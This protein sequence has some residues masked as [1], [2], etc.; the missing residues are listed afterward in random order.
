MEFPSFCQIL[1]TF[2]WL[3]LLPMHVQTTHLE[4]FAERR[5]REAELQLVRCLQAMLE[6]PKMLC[7][8][9]TRDG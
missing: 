6:I 2:E 7:L 9:L 3:V 4:T 5:E 1:D 8:N